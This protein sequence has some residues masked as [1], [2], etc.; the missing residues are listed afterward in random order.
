MNKPLY[1]ARDS[2][3]AQNRKRCTIKTFYSANVHECKD[4]SY[5]WRAKYFIIIYDYIKRRKTPHHPPIKRHLFNSY[6][7]IYKC[8]TTQKQI[9]L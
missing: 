7:G 9:S 8:K 5:F 3:K 6:S 4:N 1:F 2:I